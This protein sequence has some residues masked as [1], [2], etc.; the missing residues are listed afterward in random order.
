MIKKSATRQQVPQG[1][2]FI[3]RRFQPPENAAS[4]HLPLLRRGSGG[5]AR[6]IPCKNL[7]ISREITGQN[8]GISLFYSLV[9]A[10]YLCAM[11]F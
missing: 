2:H 1:Q 4:A 8:Q 6:E 10:L 5:G 9:S 7:K 11:N 3:N